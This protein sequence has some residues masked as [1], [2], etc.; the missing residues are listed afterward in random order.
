MALTEC[1]LRP[2]ELLELQEKSRFLQ[3]PRRVYLDTYWESPVEVRTH[4]EGELQGIEGIMRLARMEREEKV[5][6]ELQRDFAAVFESSP[7][8]DAHKEPKSVTASITLPWK[9]TPEARAREHEKKRR[10]LLQ[11]A[12]REEAKRHQ[13]ESKEAVMGQWEK[14]LAI[15]E[16]H[17][18]DVWR[19]RKDDLP[20]Q[21]WDLRRAVEVSSMP[22]SS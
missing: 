16:G 8:N 5:Q 21:S 15:V 22:T 10:K 19:N 12:E 14:R 9:N 13:R 4:T 11:M 17:Q 1:R 3:I 7:V 20:E 6:R 18:L 2:F